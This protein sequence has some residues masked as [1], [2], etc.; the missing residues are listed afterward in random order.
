LVE[1]R[2]GLGDDAIPGLLAFGHGACFSVE[3]T[4]RSLIIA[5]SRE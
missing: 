3:E 5:G 4:E 1:E 2:S